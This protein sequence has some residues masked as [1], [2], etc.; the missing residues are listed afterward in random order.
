MIIAAY[1]SW[2]TLKT[3]V[4]QVYLVFKMK[5]IKYKF[6]KGIHSVTWNHELEQEGRQ[7]HIRTL[8]ST[9]SLDLVPTVQ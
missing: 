6:L 8:E 1:L 2:Y 5:Y 9:P 4:I 3:Q 7:L